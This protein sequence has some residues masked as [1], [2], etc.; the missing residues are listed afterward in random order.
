MIDGSRSA[1]FYDCGGEARATIVLILSMFSERT[2]HVLSVATHC[3]S[4]MPQVQVQR[5]RFAACSA[6]FLALEVNDEKST[7]TM[8]LSS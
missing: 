5:A 4:V 7:T 6:V 2:G 3:A 1:P 8:S